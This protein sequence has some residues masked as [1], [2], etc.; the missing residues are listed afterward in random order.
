[1]VTRADINAGHCLR[2][3]RNFLELVRAALQPAAEEHPSNRP[4]RWVEVGH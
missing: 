1:M 2:D 3:G 4:G